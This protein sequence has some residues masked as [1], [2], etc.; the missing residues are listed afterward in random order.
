LNVSAE[1]FVLQEMTATNI[2]CRWAAQRS[3]LPKKHSSKMLQ[4]GRFRTA[5]Q[6]THQIE[7]NT[8]LIVDSASRVRRAAMP[9]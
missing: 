2:D 9:A 8:S 4:A 7:A 5:I 1:D 6:N 3:I